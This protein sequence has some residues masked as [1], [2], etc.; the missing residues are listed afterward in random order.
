MKKKYLSY[1]LCVLSMLLLVGCGK[2]KE[3]P[4]TPQPTPAVTGNVAPQPA[5]EPTIAKGDVKGLGDVFGKQLLKLSDHE[6]YFL[7]IQG[8]DWSTNDLAY[9][10][11]LYSGSIVQDD[12]IA[13]WSD[14]YGETGEMTPQYGREVKLI[15]NKDGTV[16]IHSA[17]M[18]SGKKIYF[19]KQYHSQ[20]RSA[21]QLRLK[22]EGRK[23]MIVK[24]Q[25]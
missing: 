9:M 4:A 10:S 6:T 21:C 25:Y 13:A 3:E 15:T 8:N 12:Y 5:P 19:P 18:G 20:N 16:L 7:S 24:D 22:E 2:K 17:Y 14:T 1:G 11:R 23:C